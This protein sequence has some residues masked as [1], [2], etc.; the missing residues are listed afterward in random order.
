M[1]AGSKPTHLSVVT[2]GGVITDEYR[3]WAKM[4]AEQRNLQYLEG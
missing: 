4:Y 3:A 2:A 1:P